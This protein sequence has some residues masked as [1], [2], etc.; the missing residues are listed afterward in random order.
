[1]DDPHCGQRGWREI[2]GKILSFIGFESF[3]SKNVNAQSLKW[4]LK[5]LMVYA[6]TI[7]ILQR[8]T[9]SI[10]GLCHQHFLDVKRELMAVLFTELPHLVE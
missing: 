1:M 2:G 5:M 7:N 8:Q 6:Q 4:P 10:F 9:L 3:L